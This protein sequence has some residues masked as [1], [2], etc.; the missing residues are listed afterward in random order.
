MYNIDLHTHTT[1]NQS[2]K[3]R[4]TEQANLRILSRIAALRGLDGIAVTNHNF[5]RPPR[6]VNGVVF[7]PGIEVSTTAGHV[8]VIGPNP[9]QSTAPR[10]LSPSEVVEMAHQRG[11]AAIIP[12]PHRKSN[13]KSSYASFDAVEINGKHPYTA[14]VV[15]KLAKERGVPIVGGSDAH[16]PIE[17]GNTYTQVNADELTAESV[18]EAIRSHKVEPVVNE[19]VGFKPVRL[20]HK[21]NRKRKQDLNLPSE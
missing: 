3:G 21:S 13:V 5:S 11:C 10:K 20:A 19:S 6:T 12:H 14:D 15:R 2:F 1:F 17:I 16:L 4:V 7:L 9:P 18:V 8:L